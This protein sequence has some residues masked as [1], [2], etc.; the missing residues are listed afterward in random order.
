MLEHTL[1][2][3]AC[4]ISVDVAPDATTALAEAA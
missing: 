4:G 2:C 3:P 1:S